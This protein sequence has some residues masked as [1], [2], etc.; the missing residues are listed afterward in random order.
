VAEIMKLVTP[1]FKDVAKGL[2]NIADNIEAGNYG[3]VV[4]AAVAVHGDELVVFGLGKADSTCAHYLFCCAAQKIQRP[5][6]EK[7]NEG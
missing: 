6:V 5:L 7:G 1:D 2:R 4:E 3:V